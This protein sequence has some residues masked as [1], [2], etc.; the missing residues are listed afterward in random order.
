MILSSDFT[1]AC[2][3]VLMFY[4]MFVEKRAR[5]NPVSK[6]LGMAVDNN[7]PPRSDSC[8]IVAFQILL[9]ITGRC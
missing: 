1:T 4:L 8:F 9:R 5:E 7:R 2:V 6:G 3:V